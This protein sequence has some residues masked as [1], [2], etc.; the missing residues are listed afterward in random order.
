MRPERNPVA[1]TDAQL[2]KR[3][4]ETEKRKKLER[5][6]KKIAAEMPEEPAPAGG[7]ARAAA[8]LRPHGVSRP[9]PDTPPVERVPAP[10]Q[11]DPA[12]PGVKCLRCDG[13]GHVLSDCDQ[14]KGRGTMV[15]SCRKCSGSGT[16]VQKAGPCTRCA[17]TGVLA[18]GHKCPRCKGHKVQLAFSTPCA[19][20]AGTGSLSVACKRC[21]GSLKYEAPCVTCNGTGRYHRK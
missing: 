3:K 8:P 16:Y 11:S 19:K 2:E 20:C 6:I 14:C 13:V 7:T 1:K 17:A 21:G 15:V 9:R 4:R 12:D 10:S 18:D 5:V